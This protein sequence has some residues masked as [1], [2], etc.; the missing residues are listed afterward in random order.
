M[1]G[2]AALR[3]TP[4]L[5]RPTTAGVAAALL[6]LA[7]G[8]WVLTADR[9]AGMD[10][11]PGTALGGVGWFAVSWLVMMAAMM[12]P[13]LV[14]AAL[15]SARAGGRTVAS[16]VTGYLAAWT[17]AGLVAY[18]A[19]DAVRALDPAFL[20]WDRAGRYVAAGVILLA[21]SY[22]LTAAKADC[23]D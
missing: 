18:G 23:L 6:A 17:A 10:A 16:F 5:P 4:P 11:G 15:A 8:A 1:I 19:F 20:G 3:S 12:L 22:Q 14:P 13:S 7:A 9:M 21:A 2:S